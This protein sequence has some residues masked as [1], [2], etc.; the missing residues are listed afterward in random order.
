MYNVSRSLLFCGFSKTLQRFRKSNRLP[1]F[2]MDPWTTDNIQGDCMASGAHFVFAYIL[3]L[4]LEGVLY[5]PCW[6]QCYQKAFVAIISKKIAHKDESLIDSDVRAEEERIEIID[7]KDLEVRV[8]KFRKVYVTG[9]RSATLA[10]DRASFGLELGE[11]FALLGVNG[12][13]KTTVFK[14]L[15]NEAVPT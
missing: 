4:I 11:C 14:S 7:P 1:E 3:I 2:E 5:L 10:V 15:T 13:G 9:I 6:Q 8:S 12:A